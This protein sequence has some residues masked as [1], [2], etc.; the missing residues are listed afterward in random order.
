[1]DGWTSLTL[2]ERAAAGWFPRLILRC[3]TAENTQTKRSTKPNFL[4]IV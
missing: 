3:L 4:N 2:L 1:M